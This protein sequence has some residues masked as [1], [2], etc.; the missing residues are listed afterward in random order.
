MNQSQSIKGL[1]L[2]ALGAVLL[3]LGFFNFSKEEVLSGQGGVGATSCTIVASTTVG[4][5]HQKSVE[6]VASAA[7]N[8]YVI[9]SQPVF[10]TNTVA[11]GLDGEA[12]I[13]TSAYKL[14]PGTASTSPERLVLG[15][16]SDFPFTGSIQARTNVG[17][18]TI[19]VTVCRY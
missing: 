15:L 4:I 5:G 17:S 6:I 1:A 2:I 9:I 3:L 18:T 14:A 12:N 19:G 13:T 10:A 11:L 7:N 8:A 16:N